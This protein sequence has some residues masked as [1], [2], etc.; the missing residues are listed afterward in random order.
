METYGSHHISCV[1]D[2]LKDVAEV[3]GR[4]GL[5]VAVVV[6][7][8]LLCQTRPAGRVQAIAFGSQYTPPPGRLGCS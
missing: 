7:A 2:R 8:L 1:Q 6:T 5:L 3:V 4:I